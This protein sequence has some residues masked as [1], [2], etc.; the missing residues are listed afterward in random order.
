MVGYHAATP[1]QAQTPAPMPVVEALGGGEAR[2]RAYADQAA[3]KAREDCR[4]EMAATQAGLSATLV[5]VE[6]KLDDLTDSTSV[7]KAD[8]AVLKSDVGDMKS[9][10]RK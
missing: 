5:R 3:D 2:S 7:L 8:V 6:K 10:R 4:R 9:S 1:A